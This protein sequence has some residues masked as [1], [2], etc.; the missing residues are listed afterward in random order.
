[1]GWKSFEIARDAGVETLTTAGKEKEVCEYYVCWRK[2]WDRYRKDGWDCAHNDGAYDSDLV[3]RCD[4]SRGLC[5][6][7]DV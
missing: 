4:F 2:R 6:D 3:G 7:L 5:S 1:M